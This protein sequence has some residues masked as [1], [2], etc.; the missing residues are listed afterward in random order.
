MKRWLP[1]ALAPPQPRT[2]RT[3]RAAPGAWRPRL[4]RPDTTDAR[5]ARPTAVPRDPAPAALA[6]PPRGPNR[7]GT[8]RRPQRR[9]SRVR[10]PSGR[11]TPSCRRSARGLRHI[12]R[13]RRGG[14]GRDAPERSGHA[15][16]SFSPRPAAA[17]RTSLKRSRSRTSAPSAVRAHRLVRRPLHAGGRVGTHD[18]T[19][20]PRPA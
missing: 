13:A 19:E 17:S 6:R 16:R 15:T 18:A 10:R 4:A 11:A 3:P 8:S 5:G 2:A 7:V 1:R 12:P 9:R 14:R 20:A